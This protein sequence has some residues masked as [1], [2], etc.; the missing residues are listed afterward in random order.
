[1]SC[2]NIRRGLCKI[3]SLNCLELFCLI[4]IAIKHETYFVDGFYFLRG[5]FINYYYLKFDVSSLALCWLEIILNSCWCS[6]LIVLLLLIF[7]FFGWHI[8]IGSF[9][10]TAN[11]KWKNLVTNC[12]GD[13]LF[14]WAVMD[15]FK[16]FTIWWRIA[17]QIVKKFGD[18]SL[19]WRIISVTICMGA[20]S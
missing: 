19:Q 2:L 11:N 1:M 5:H 17:L 13:L 20:A 15:C 9:K 3:T 6:Y 7:P 12:F 18:G 16:H 10:L 8:C 14:C 4:E